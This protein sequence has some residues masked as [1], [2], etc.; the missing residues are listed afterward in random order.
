MIYIYTV[1]ACTCSS[2]IHNLYIEYNYIHVYNYNIYIYIYIIKFYIY[3]MHVYNI[4]MYN[5]R[6]II[7]F[8]VSHL[9]YLDII[10]IFT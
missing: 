9:E 7:L 10:L 1:I 8:I 2:F 4:H 6:N 5:I 3:N